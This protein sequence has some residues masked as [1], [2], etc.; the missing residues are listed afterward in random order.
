[1]TL[2]SMALR[3]RLS[4]KLPNLPDMTTASFVTIFRDL[5]TRQLRAHHLRER[6]PHPTSNLHQIQPPCFLLHCDIQ[7]QPDTVG[8]R[9]AS[10]SRKLK[11]GL[12]QTHSCKQ[13]GPNFNSFGEHPKV[14]T[15]V[16]K[17]K[18]GSWVRFLVTHE[19]GRAS[20]C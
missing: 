15:N 7:M 4:V 18:G 6:H 19:I 13:E 16:R 5:K 12:E 1:M 8:S 17:M 14:K 20:T 11:I 10:D 9:Q 3:I 2:L